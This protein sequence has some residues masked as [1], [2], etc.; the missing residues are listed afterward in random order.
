LA[1]NLLERT[2]SALLAEKAA[3][4]GMI[5]VVGRARERRG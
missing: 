5:G 2:S 4:G 1:I 3:D